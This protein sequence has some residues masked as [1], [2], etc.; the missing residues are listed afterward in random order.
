[1]PSANH[2]SRVPIDPQALKNRNTLTVSVGG[3][4]AD[5]I[6]VAAASILVDLPVD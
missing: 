1:M 3:D 4:R 5:G 2:V 6:R